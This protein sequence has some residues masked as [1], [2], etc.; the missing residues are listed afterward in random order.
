MC[1]R[2]RIDVYPC[3]VKGTGAVSEDTLTDAN[4]D[5]YILF[6]NCNRTDT[7]AFFAMKRNF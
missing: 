4:G 6:Q 7:W 3:I 2:D 5:T 1:I